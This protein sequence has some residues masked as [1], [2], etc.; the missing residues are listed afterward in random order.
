MSGTMTIRRGSPAMT[1]QDLGRSGLLQIGLSAGGAADRM[2]VLES[3]ALLGQPAEM[4]VIEMG[5]MGGQFVAD[6]ILRLSLT[7]APMN[8]RVEGRNLAWNAV[9]RLEAGQVLDVGA[10]V[11]GSYGYLGIGGG[12]AT[13]P[14]LGSRASHLVAGIGASLEAGDTL[15]LGDDDRLAEPAMTLSVADRMNGGVVR[16]IV[17]PHSELF[18]EPAHAAFQSMAF[19]R[20]VRGNRQG[21][22]LLRDAAPIAVSNQ[23]T[24]VSEAITPGD[25]Q[26][27]GDGTPFILLSECQTIGGY[28]RIG[29]VLPQDLPIIAQAPAGAAISFRAV[30]RDEAMSDWQT[31]AA[32]LAALTRRLAPLVRD[33]ASMPDLLAYQLISG[34]WSGEE[35]I[36]P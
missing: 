34:V 6:R 1:V 18:S 8:A 35:N 24:I 17:G 12:I 7:G 19:T 13:E 2:A 31:P 23:L 21:V 27:T 33:P 36:C 9:H 16:Y 11:S 22:R 26:I 10:V 30:T 5:T 3:A 28:P 20:D 14:V 29:T 15:P 32:S 25:I 4:A